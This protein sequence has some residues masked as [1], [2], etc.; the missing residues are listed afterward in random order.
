MDI[1]DNLHYSKIL[2]F[3]WYMVLI[4]PNVEQIFLIETKILW[5][6]IFLLIFY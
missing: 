6:I 2:S 3:L 5:A 1:Y 4:L